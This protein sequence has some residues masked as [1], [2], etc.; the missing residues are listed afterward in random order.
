MAATIVACVIALGACGTDSGRP[1]S[2]TDETPVPSPEEDIQLVCTNIPFPAERLLKRGA[3]NETDAAAA[4]LRAVLATNEGFI[5]GVRFPRSGWT[6]VAQTADEVQFVALETRIPEDRPW[7]L[8]AFQLRNGGWVRHHTGECRLRPAALPAGFGPGEWWLA[9]SAEPTDRSVSA[10]VRE[11]ACS[12]GPARPDSIGAPIV[13]QR[14]GEVKVVVPVRVSANGG[15]VGATPI[16]IDIGQPLGTRR[17]V[18]AQVFP[19]RNVG[20][21]RP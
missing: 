1:P 14:Q 12:V 3:E 11:A 6:R 2:T 10:F 15:C 19:A 7:Y 20:T 9:T 18:D 8:I 17:L 21:T 5:E 16:T 13:V 4:A